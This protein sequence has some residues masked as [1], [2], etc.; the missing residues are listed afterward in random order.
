[1][2]Q[3]EDSS[4][5]EALPASEAVVELLKNSGDNFN[6]DGGAI[7]VPGRRPRSKAAKRAAAT[8]SKAAKETSEPKPVVEKLA[9]KA[10]AVEKARGYLKAAEAEWKEAK[11]EQDTA[12]AAVFAAEQAYADLKARLGLQPQSLRRSRRQPVC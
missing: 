3:R 8:A 1:M 12:E 5:D 7:E 9:S 11:S 6:L 2:Q 10:T 4:R